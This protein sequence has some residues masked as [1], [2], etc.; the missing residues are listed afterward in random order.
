MFEGLASATNGVPQQ[1]ESTSQSYAEGTLASQVWSEFSRARTE[2]M[3]RD[4]EWWVSW[5]WY[6]GD[7]SVFLDRAAG[8]IYKVSS[9][10]PRH[11]RNLPLNLIGLSID[12][13]VAKQMRA[14]PV[15]DAGAVSR[16]RQKSRLAAREVRDLVRYLWD[17]NELKAERRSLFLDRNITGNGFI[18]VFWDGN[19]APFRDDII[20]CQTCA[21]SGKTQPPP[22]L[23]QMAQQAQQM[24]GMAPVMPDLGPC[25]L[26]QGAGQVNRGRIPLGDVSIQ[27]VSPWEVWPAA[28][29]KKI[30]QGCFHG[31]KLSK[32]EAASRY[33]IPISEV[34]PSSDLERGESH[35][36]TLA[37]TNRIDSKADEDAVW[38]VERWLPPAPKTES[39]RL[40]ILVGNRIV[41]PKPE[42]QSF[43]SGSTTEDVPKFMRV[44]F[45]HF[46]LRPSAEQFWSSGIVLDMIS[47]NDF[48]NRARASFHRHQQTM[49]FTKWFYEEGT[50]D[51]DRLVAEEG[52]AVPY[53]GVKA[54]EQR[55]PAGMPQFYVDLFQR[56]MDF[57]PQLAGIN[58]IDKGVAPPNIEA[59][60][61]LHFLAEQSETVHG[62]VYLEDERQWR[63]VAWAATRCAVFKYKP[64]DVR[65]LAVGGSAVEVKAMLEIDLSDCIDIRCETGSALAHSP[66]LRQEMVYRAIEAGGITPQEARA[67]GLFDFGVVLGEDAD[68]HRMQE[69]VAHQENEQIAEG[70]AQPQFPTQQLDPMTGQVVMVPPPINHSCGTFTHD[71]QVHIEVHRRAALE[72]QMDGNL[73]LW[74]AMEQACGQHMQSLQMMMP[75]APQA[76]VA[77]AAG[78]PGIDQA[79]G[80]QQYGT[81]P[82]PVA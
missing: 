72:A 80:Q 65:L 71:H 11:K 69:A 64:A 61:A 23:L 38:V 15:F 4:Y 40:T 54:P 77:G 20:Q 59:F 48:V 75:Q 14:E 57:I 32:E 52:E 30:S 50:V 60:Q 74:Q 37:R 33:G 19:L 17:K 70:M 39:P 68:D 46:R 79:G 29:A 36:S 5:Q 26:C 8:Q 9:R 67:R 16:M 62:P 31:F 55:S 10:R 27:V 56:E 47:A 53:R 63:S 25:P 76:G 3:T 51:S 12:L 28:G 82:P 73:Q 24:Y 22:E 45:F 34:K 58:D 43:A 81:S 66:A 6:N 13:L 42:S 78:K 35:F 44:P 41:W 49:A 2:R 7:T 21:G 18:K 1:P